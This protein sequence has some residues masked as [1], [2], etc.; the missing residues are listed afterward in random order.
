MRP[1]THS[2]PGNCIRPAPPPT[3]PDWDAGGEDERHTLDTRNA[4]GQTR[5]VAGPRARAFAERTVPVSRA[6]RRAQP[7]AYVCSASHRCW[8]SASS[9]V[10][11]SP[12]SLAEVSAPASTEPLLGP[13]LRPCSDSFAF[14]SSCSVSSWKLGSSGARGSSSTAACRGVAGRVGIRAACTCVAVR[15]RVSPCVAVC[16]PCVCRVFA[17]GL[18]CVAVRL[19]CVAVCLPCVCRVFAVCLPCVAVRRRASPRVAVC[20]P[21][22]CRV[23]AVCLPCVCR[24]FA[25]CRRVAGSPCSTTS[26][27]RSVSRAGWATSKSTRDATKSACNRM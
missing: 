23:F 9:A 21:C 17:V 6:R 8:S 5:A 7:W 14:S 25:V 18:P 26:H 20:F 13:A 3:G 16:L 24:V 22:V 4:T 2:L 27:S 15:R 10:S 12:R 19:P 11:P 1:S